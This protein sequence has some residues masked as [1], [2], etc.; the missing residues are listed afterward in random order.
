MALD[1]GK[2]NPHCFDMSQKADIVIAG[3]GLNGLAMALALGGT[4]C[5]MPL[6]VTVLERQGA[7]PAAAEVSDS[8]ASAIT[9]TSRALFEALG[10]WDAIAPH[11]EAMREIIVTDS[12][13]PGE[14][15]PALLHF[16]EK[17]DNRWP[18][19]YM[20]ENRFLLAALHRA[21]SEAPQIN[22]RFETSIR[23]ADRGAGKVRVTTSHD[24]EINCPLVIAAD[25]RN[26]PL[27]QAAGIETVGWSYR[28]CGIVTTVAHEL[29]HHGRAEE[30]FLPGGPFAILPL[31]RNRASI[32][33]TET[34]AEAARLTGLG[35]EAFLAVLAARF[36]TAHGA[37]RV[38][39]PVQ[40]YPLAMYL[41][42]SFAARR[43]ALIG[44]AVH[45]V[46]P[47][48]G[49]GFN[50]GLRDVA[51]LAEC[52]ADAAHIG[53]DIGGDSVLGRYQE[54]R[55]FDTVATALATDGLNRLF[56][57]DDAIL[58]PLRDA[59]LKAVNALAPLKELF[60]REAAGQTGSLPRLMR[61]EPA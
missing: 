35:Q 14:A 4:T 52:I 22:M 17:P 43:L 7:L 47:I 41:A 16:L 23:H 13:A 37:L 20:V 31:P 58:R 21:A 15:R 1:R 50:L 54:W 6:R 26:S 57:N 55:R 9:A 32:V 59:G 3:G 45:V 40:S 49:L 53:L 60:M 36:G 46:H 44:D 30:H 8:R 2:R 38:E 5:R 19:A 48:A 12:R 10:V 56:A 61:G 27:R 33:W 25:G 42:R 24:E 29:P 34:E 18:S 11:A 51:A 39:G 28:Q